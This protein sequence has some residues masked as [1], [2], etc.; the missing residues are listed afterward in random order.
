MTEKDMKALVERMYAA[1]MAGDVDAVDEIF[2]PGFYSHPMRTTGVEAVKNAWREILARYPELRVEA[3]QIVAEGDTVAVRASV[4]P[5][6]GADGEP[7]ALMEM[8]R[9]EDGRIAELWAA[10][11]VS[12]R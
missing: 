8:M 12:L 9:V 7:A 11:N 10:S 3:D 1:A 5:R 6:P 4:Y 2:A